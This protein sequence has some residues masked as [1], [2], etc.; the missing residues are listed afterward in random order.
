VKNASGKSG[1]E[2]F[3]EVI[4]MKKDKS[5]CKGCYNDDYNHG[6]GGSKECWGYAEATIV[7]RLAIRSDQPPPYNA[8]NAEPMMSCYKKKGMCY[9]NPNVLTGKGYWK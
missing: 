6:L 3:F 7:P 9:V 1:S 5:M 4:K 2:G 8:E